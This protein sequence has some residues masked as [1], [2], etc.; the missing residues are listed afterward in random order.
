MVTTNWWQIVTNVG[1]RLNAYKERTTAP[2]QF[3]FHL[4]P[5]FWLSLFL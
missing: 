2:C 5:N 4:L 1:S 3:S